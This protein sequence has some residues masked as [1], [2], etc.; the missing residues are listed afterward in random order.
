MH[1]HA[2][3]ESQAQEYSPAAAAPVTRTAIIY[4][5]PFLYP[6]ISSSFDRNG[7]VDIEVEILDSCSPVALMAR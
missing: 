7:E 3:S 5:P 6:A 4:S 2:D 1:V